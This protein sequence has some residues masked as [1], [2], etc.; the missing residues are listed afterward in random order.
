MKNNTILTMMKKELARFFGDRRMVMTTLLMPG[1]MIFLL[2]NFMGDAM[3]S[4][5]TT[6]KFNPKCLV[7][8]LPDGWEEPLSKQGFRI[9][10][11]K[12]TTDKQAKQK[13]KEKKCELLVV[14]PEDFLDQVAEYKS[15]SGTAAPQVAVYY[16]STVTDSMTAYTTLQ[17]YLDQYESSLANKFDVNSDQKESYD[18]AT[19]KDTTGKMFSTLLPFLLLIFLY[20]GCISIA[21]ESIAGE[22]ERGT[23]ASLLI[24]PAKRSHIALGKISALSIIAVL[25]GAS[26]AIGTIASAP[27]LMSGSEGVIDNASYTVTDYILL[28]IVILSTALVLVTLISLVSA[29]ARTIKEAQTYVTPLM[30]LV[31]LIGITAMF[32][33]GAKEGLGYYAIPLYNSVQAMVGIFSFKAI[34]AQIVFTI[35]ANI[36][37][38]GLGTV[39]LAKM[40]DSEYVMF[41]K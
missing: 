9:E 14:F 32:G 10:D 39:I 19:E 29:F 8:N 28:G 6:E 27:N 18:L 41:H 20:S 35:A 36:V 21:P 4:Q 40:F 17:E 16:D 30:I 2:Y 13:I 37:V 31:M 12:D 25:S 3:E 26:S 24:T 1:L 7:A 22:K 23:I 11:L 15:A 5:F 33:D 38:T 34:P